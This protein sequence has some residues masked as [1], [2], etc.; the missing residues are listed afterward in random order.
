[1]EKR[2]IKIIKV[3]SPK[4]KNDKMKS[5]LYLFLSIFVLLSCSDNDSNFGIQTEADILK[6]IEDNSLNATKSDS[7]LYM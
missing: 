2:F 5:Y 4:L 6:Y 3:Y 1:M 7:G